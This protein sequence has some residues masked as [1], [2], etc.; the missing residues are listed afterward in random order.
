MKLKE[1]HE[2]T[3]RDEEQMMKETRALKQQMQVLQEQ[4]KRDADGLNEQIER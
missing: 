2:K 3:V 1:A 4:Y